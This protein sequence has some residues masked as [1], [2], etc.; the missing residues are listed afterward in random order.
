MKKITVVFFIL[1]LIF[2]LS[3]CGKTEYNGTTNAAKSDI[4]ES[5]D[6]S[7]QG[8]T[9]YSDESYA[10]TSETD[11]AKTYSIDADYFKTD[12]RQS[13]ITGWL[14]SNQNKWDSLRLIDLDFDGNPEAVID[15]VDR[16]MWNTVIS[17]SGS[18]VHELK[19]TEPFEGYSVSVKK[20]T[21]VY[22]NIYTNT[23]HWFTIVVEY[24]EYSDYPSEMSA[25]E[26]SLNLSDD[27]VEAKTVFSCSDGKFFT[28]S[29]EVSSEKYEKAVSEWQ[30]TYRAIRGTDANNAVSMD[31]P[32]VDGMSRGY[33]EPDTIKSSF[34]SAY[35]KWETANAPFEKTVNGLTA[36][37]AVKVIICV[38]GVIGVVSA[39]IQ[40]VKIKRLKAK[41]KANSL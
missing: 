41:S 21:E 6:L 39:I 26:L 16:D 5:T 7:T 23:L 30:N 2:A 17:S 3:A 12:N 25:Y 14:Y 37:F 35:K 18:T 31:N 1:S 11:E 27:I 10:E 8:S 36:R 19:L 9:Y 24:D 13:G 22:Q 33:S 34:E 40:S 28:G 15:S 38:I 32:G 20:Q 29:N 4:T